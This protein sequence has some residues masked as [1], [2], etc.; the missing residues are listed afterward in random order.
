MPVMRLRPRQKE[1]YPG[2]EVDS[3]GGGQRLKEQGFIRHGGDG[4]S[5]TGPKNEV[6]PVVALGLAPK[7][8]FSSR[9]CSSWLTNQAGKEV[10]VPFPDAAMRAWPISPRV[11]SPKNNDPDLLSSVGA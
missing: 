9:E 8:R 7:V 5:A 11:N 3:K 2:C 6:Y 10:L 1:V 4:S